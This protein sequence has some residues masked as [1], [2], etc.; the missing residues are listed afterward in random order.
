MK[1]RQCPKC[2]AVIYG[3]AKFCVCGGLLETQTFPDFF[4]EMINKGENESK[5]HSDGKTT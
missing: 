4:N 2:G 3:D 1:S 5:T